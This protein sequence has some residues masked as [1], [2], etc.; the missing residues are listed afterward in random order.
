MHAI[1]GQCRWNPNKLAKMVLHSGAGY[2]S[3]GLVSFPAQTACSNPF[4]CGHL[5]A[6]SDT[7][8]R[9]ELVTNLH[10]F[11]IGMPFELTTPHAQ[12][13]TRAVKSPSFWIRSVKGFCIQPEQ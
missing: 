9:S 5:S 4:G 13:S 1:A 8:K 10:G 7:A 6:S 11:R 2:L 3:V 12:P